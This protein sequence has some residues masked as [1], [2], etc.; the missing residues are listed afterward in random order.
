MDFSIPWKVCVCV[1][2]D[3]PFP[4]VTCLFF[5]LLLIFCEI[6]SCRESAM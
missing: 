2:V 5:A 1:Y 3:E 4:P 6:N